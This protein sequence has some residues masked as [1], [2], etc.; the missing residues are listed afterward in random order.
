MAQESCNPHSAI[1]HRPRRAVLFSLF[2]LM[3]LHRAAVASSAAVT[4]SAA[5]SAEAET[6]FFEVNADG[7]PVLRRVGA[8]DSTKA[9]K[10]SVFAAAVLV[11]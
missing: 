3:Q 11:S 9:E 8:S 7:S 6:E 2:L 5:V 10:V 4:S 1:M